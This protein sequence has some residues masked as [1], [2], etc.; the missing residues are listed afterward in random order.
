MKQD[1]CAVVDAAVVADITVCIVGNTD[2]SV[3]WLVLVELENMQQPPAVREVEL[4]KRPAVS[5]LVAEEVEQYYQAQ[6]MV[7]VVGAG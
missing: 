7:R 5:V 2:F 6:G 3:R 4:V 1:C